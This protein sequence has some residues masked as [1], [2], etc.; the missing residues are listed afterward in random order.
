MVTVTLA[1]NNLGFEFDLNYERA[2]EILNE[3]NIEFRYW[4]DGDFTVKRAEFQD[5][6]NMLQDAVSE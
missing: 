4:G 5:A 3:N 6:V 1:G 2:V